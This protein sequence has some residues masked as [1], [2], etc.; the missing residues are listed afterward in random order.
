MAAAVTMKKAMATLHGLESTGSSSGTLKWLVSFNLRN[1]TL[2]QA[3]KRWIGLRTEFQELDIKHSQIR[4]PVSAKVMCDF[5][6][7][8]VVRIV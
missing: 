3:D 4:H 2:N 6:K 8:T 7:Q 5:F 1:S